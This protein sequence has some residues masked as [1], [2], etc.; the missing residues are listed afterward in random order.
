[1]KK[2]IL[3]AVVLAGPDGSV[4]DNDSFDPFC[5]QE[6]ERNFTTGEYELDLC[7]NC[8]KNFTIIGQIRDKFEAAGGS[9]KSI[10]SDAQVTNCLDTYLPTLLTSE[11]PTNHQ[12][13]ENETDI[14]GYISGLVPKQQI[15][16]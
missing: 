14:E 13:W 1:M 3:E 15:F 7:M 8:Y 2:E 9:Y 11:T 4:E 10:P 5:H 16:F 12:T 6:C